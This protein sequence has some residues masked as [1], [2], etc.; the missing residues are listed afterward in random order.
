M[1]S[2][3]IWA[4]AGASSAACR[5]MG[6]TAFTDALTISARE[7]RREVQALRTAALE[8]NASAAGGEP[9]FRTIGLPLYALLLQNGREVVGARRNTVVVARPGSDW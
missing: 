4:R 3:F 6:A 2:S 8:P 1:W 5:A 7:S 9:G